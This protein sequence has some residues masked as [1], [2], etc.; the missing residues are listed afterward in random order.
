MSTTHVER[1][2]SGW[3]GRAATASASALA[4]GTQTGTPDDSALGTYFPEQAHGLG[5]RARGLGWFSLGL[6]LA[7]LLATRAFARAIGVGDGGPNR[8]LIRALGARELLFGVGILTSRRAA[9]WLWSRVA[10]DAMD[11]ALLATALGARA[12][13]KWER[14]RL[15]FALVAVAG[16]T[17]MDLVT[18][19]QMSR[20]EKT[21]VRPVAGAPVPIRS[22]ITIGRSPEEVYAF[23][24][25]FQ[26]LPAFMTNVKAVQV[27]DDLRSR[28]SVEV[29]GKSL[30][31][32]ARI[33][34]DR[35]NQSIA[36]QTLQESQVVHSGTVRFARAP[37]GR[38]TEIHVSMEVYPPGGTIGRAAA[39]LGRMV[40]K[41]QITNDL[42]RL[43]QGLEVGEV[44]R[45]DASI[46]SGPHPARP[47][48]REGGEGT[49]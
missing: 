26:N 10:G 19:W 39:K 40:P 24:R 34:G 21:G 2:G 42:R 35:P 14:D 15:S 43:K 1:G 20:A 25:D 9:P 7:E 23:W 48:G 46:H 41:E 31:W 30:E 13:K 16:A 36:W 38:G 6:G 49:R 5:R 29:A 3:D 17:A 44:V 27:L 12:T 33:T 18:G 28:W 22:S 4:T 11:L 8:L 37:G 45:S 47:S 32:V